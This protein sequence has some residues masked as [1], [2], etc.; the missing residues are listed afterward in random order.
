MH[1]ASNQMAAGRNAAVAVSSTAGTRADLGRIESNE[2][3]IFTF[4]QEYETQM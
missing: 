1:A 2:F 4:P 3:D